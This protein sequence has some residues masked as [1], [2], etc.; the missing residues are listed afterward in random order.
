[1][2]GV[3]V[4]PGGD[5]RIAPGVAWCVAC[6]DA[7]SGWTVLVAGVV[8]VIRVVVVVVMVNHFGHLTLASEIL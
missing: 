8:V 5:G 7:F 3:R 6:L 1:M 2:V 4:G